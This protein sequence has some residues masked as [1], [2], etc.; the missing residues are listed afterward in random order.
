M[1][2]DP[3]SLWVEV[4]TWSPYR[5]QRIL[6]GRISREDFLAL[7]E[8]HAPVMVRLDDCQNGEAPSGAVQ[9][10]FLASSHILSVTPLHRAA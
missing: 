8:G 1:H 6:H 4:E 5:P 7:H 10:L 3:D 2:H 9:D